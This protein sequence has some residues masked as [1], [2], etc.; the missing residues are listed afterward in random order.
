MKQGF[1]RI[2]ILLDRSGSM[3]GSEES[4]ISGLNKFFAEQK[5][6]PGNATVRFCQFDTVSYDVVFDVYLQ[7]VPE[8]LAKDFNPRA[9][10]PLWDSQA[11]IINEL[12]VE[13]AALSERDRPENVLVVTMT[14][15]EENASKEYTKASM[16]KALIEEQTNK[17]GWTFV[18]L[19]ANQDAVKVGRAMGI[20]M[21]NSMTYDVGERGVANTMNAIST[22]TKTLRA[23][24]SASFSEKDRVEAMQK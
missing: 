1:T 8:L 5:A 12:G 9:G 14:D 20:S 18:Y 15:G 19:G 4:V 11:R 13:L 7:Q 2:A 10:T 3:R 16:V 17:Y 23:T 24:R 6:L 21:Q 22:Y